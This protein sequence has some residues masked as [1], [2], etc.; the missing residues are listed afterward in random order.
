MRFAVSAP[1]VGDPAALIE[2]ALAAEAGGWDAFFLWD[3]LHLVRE[4]QV[5]VHDPW[6]VLGAVAHAT[7]RILLGTMVTPLPR[8]RPWTL[9]K[10]VV[11]L[12]HLSDG[13]VVIGVGLGYPAGE[14][15]EAFGEAGSEH[16][17]A[18]LLDEGLQ[19]FDGCLRGG[20]FTH[21]GST[22]KLDV[23]LH[24]APRQ[25]PRP[26]IWIAG[27]WPNRGPVQRARRF[28]GYVPVSTEGGPLTPV[29]IVDIVAAIQPPPGFDIVSPWAEG[30][31]PDEYE[32]AGATW[33]I[34]SRWPDGDWYEELLDCARRGPR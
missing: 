4:M 26:P 33:L 30:H 17:R 15:F 7:E 24:P 8:R 13:R 22:F 16:R 34:D 1:D 29:D 21:Q 14:E 9:A 12:D 19:V 5:D 28:D 10:Q 23:D 27:M 25:L 11:T 31:S 3:H 6:V 2:L 20:P 32:A 18:A